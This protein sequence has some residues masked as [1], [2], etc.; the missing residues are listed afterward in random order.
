[1]KKNGIS[2]GL[3]ILFTVLCVSIAQADLILNPTDDTWIRSGEPDVNKDGNPLTGF[4][5][6]VTNA[7]TGN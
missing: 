3:A 4:V 7:E 1:M 2:I 5:K 6:F